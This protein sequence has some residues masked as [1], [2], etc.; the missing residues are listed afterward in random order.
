MNG[1]PSTLDEMICLQKQGHDAAL[2]SVCSAHPWALKAAMR[3]AAHTGET[4][5][6]EATCNQVNQFGGYTGMTPA[7]FV[8]Y[9]RQIGDENHLP[10]ERLILGGDHLGP[11]VWQAEPQSEAMS[12]AG[13]LAAAYARAGFGKI[14]LDASMR[15]GDDPPG[16]LATE[17]SARRSA[18]LAQSVENASAELG[19][20][21]PRYV[22]G[23]EVPVPGGVVGQAEGVSVTRVSDAGETVELTRR[24]FYALGLQKAWERVIALVVQPGVE[25][26]DDFVLDY[27]PLKAAGLARWIESAPGL[28]FEAHSTD[29]QKRSALQQL[30]RDHFGILKVGPALT[31]AFR[32]AVFGLALMETELYGRESSSGLIETLEAQM[33]QHPEHWRSYYQGDAATQRWKRKYSLSDR[34]RYYWT[35]PEVQQALNRM[36]ANLN[37]SPLPLGLLSQ[38]DLPF[39]RLVR[40]G[41]VKN[42]AV[43][44]I[45]SKIEAAL[46]DY[47]PW[48]SGG[49]NP[50]DISLAPNLL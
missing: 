48:P 46:A 19:N 2:T 25:F 36:L 45:L 50:S 33:I 18:L 8:Q 5:L 28:V 1:L 47:S 12:K 4:L 10:P 17:V 41:Q 20:P 6:V 7:V 21:G 14:H 27:Q 34:V 40:N 32:E 26:G 13:E 9:V 11:S 15:L 30:R 39:Y 38:Y 23:T 35:I 29:Y 37:D 43:Q 24:A 16:P 3:R 44:V 42:C 49:Y 31:Y 22:I